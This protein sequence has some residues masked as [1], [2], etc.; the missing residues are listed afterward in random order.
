MAFGQSADNI[1]GLSAGG[2]MASIVPLDPVTDS[3]MEATSNFLPFS[4]TRQQQLLNNL[5]PHFKILNSA[6]SASASLTSGPES[7]LTSLG[8]S[9]PSSP[10]A[11]PFTLSPGE[12]ASG[13]LDKPSP[14]IDPKHIFVPVV[15]PSV[16]D[17]DMEKDNMEEARHSSN[18]EKSPEPESVQSADQITGLSD[19]DNLVSVCTDPLFSSPMGI[20]SDVPLVSSTRQQHPFNDHEPDIDISNPPSPASASFTF[21]PGSPL[22]SLATTPHGSP[23]TDLMAFALKETLC[24]PT[25]FTFGPESYVTS[26]ATTPPGS[27]QLSPMELAIIDALMARRDALCGRHD[28]PSLGIDPKVICSSAIPPSVVDEDLE[29]DSME[30]ASHSSNDHESDL[31]NNTIME[32]PFPIPATQGNIAQDHDL[33]IAPDCALDFTPTDGGLTDALNLLFTDQNHNPDNTGLRA[34]SKQVLGMP[35]IQTLPP[36]PDAHFDTLLHN[37]D[38]IL[39]EAL[40]ALVGIDIPDSLAHS[41]E[42]R[43]S[44]VPDQSNAGIDPNLIC[45]PTV[46]CTVVDEDMEKDNMAKASHSSNHDRIPEPESVQRGNKKPSLK[47]S[48]IKSLQSLVKKKLRR[49]KRHNAWAP[50]PGS[51]LFPIYF[52]LEGDVST[53]LSLSIYDILRLKLA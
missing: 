51:K 22:T 47:P 8:T 23:Q 1:T 39:E 42:E 18:H 28:N 52:D 34:P 38:A 2:N 29:K 15:P 49:R 41:P 27:P 7:P 20:T 14:G 17:Q 32:T 40:V 53:A 50:E 30:E 19:N 24:A 5:D 33:N 31:S 48:A 25:S 6:S 11:D 21:G 13:L 26:L 45:A 4:P 10:Q 12:T 46:P 16:V 36:T 9:P 44:E 35:T 43:V 37:S 3:P